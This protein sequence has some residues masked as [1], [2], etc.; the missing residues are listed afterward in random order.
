MMDV[1]TYDDL[2]RR[3]E[4]IIAS[5]TRRASGAGTFADLTGVIEGD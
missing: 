3:L 1:L 2:L 5:L 4:S